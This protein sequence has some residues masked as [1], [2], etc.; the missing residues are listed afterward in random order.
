[1]IGDIHVPLPAGLSLIRKR[2][3]SDEYWAR[4]AS[5][6]GIKTTDA[7]R[8]VMSPARA[9]DSNISLLPT[10]A[11]VMRIPIYDGKN[12]IVWGARVNSTLASMNALTAIEEDVEVSSMTAKQLQSDS[13]AKGLIIGLTSPTL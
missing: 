7:P 6:R 10:S 5:R 12:F 3:R 9:M 13:I 11:T 2:E 1:M 4:T 8:S